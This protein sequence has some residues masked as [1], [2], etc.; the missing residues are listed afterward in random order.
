M[1]GIDLKIIH[2]EL[3][4]NPCTTLFRQK[5]RKVTPEYHQA[6]EKEL[7]KLLEAGFIKEVKYP[8]W[9]SNMVIVPKKNRGVRI[10][11]DFTN[12]N[13]A[14]PK[15][16]YPLP[17]IDQLVEAVEGFGIPAEIVSDN[18]KKLQGKNID[19][20]FDTFKIR[21]NKSTPI[22]PQS[23]GHAEA[24]NQTLA[25]ILKKSLDEHKGRWC[26]QLHNALWAYRTTR[27]SATGE[28]PFLLTYGAEAVIPT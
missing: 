11:I 28:Y 16:S 1:T 17:S 12:L 7:R 8:T 23:N 27:R 3:R 18:G 14:C 4:I 20:H 19:M 22:Y 13:K 2:H 9:I 24:T 10:C 6:I 21:K 15:D 26:E 5:V 25:L